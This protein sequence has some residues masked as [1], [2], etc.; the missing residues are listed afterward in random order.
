MVDIAAAAREAETVRK[1][2]A[3]QW[4]ELAGVLARAFEDDPVYRW[5]VPDD[6]RRVPLAERGFGLYLRRFWPDQD[7]CY[8]T[9]S[10]AGAAVWNPPGQWKLGLGQQIRLAPAMVTIYLDRLPRLLKFI[11]RIESGHP[12]E[13]HYYLP[14]LGVD[15]TWQGRGIGGALLRPV[16]D[17]CDRERMPAYLEASSPRNRALYE[18]NG[19]EVTEELRLG[20]GSPPVWRMW[21]NARTTAATSSALRSETSTSGSASRST[22]S[23]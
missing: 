6:S 18:R 3:D 19:F 8:T 9:D 2:T 4:P 12:D 21:R 16:L 20:R 1:A 17:R 13:P 23:K 22:R 11:A 5:I 14:F 15:P 10:V 7:L